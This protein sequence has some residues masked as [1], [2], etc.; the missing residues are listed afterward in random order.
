M[1]CAKQKVEKK[2]YKAMI[3]KNATVLNDKFQF[4][5]ADVSINNGKFEKIGEKLEG[6]IETFDVKGNRIIPGYINIHMHGGV[7]YGVNNADVEGYNKLGRY[8]ASTGTTSYLMTAA[9][10]PKD[11]LI[12][13]VGVIK[14]AMDKGC[15]GANLLGINLEGP[16]LSERYKGAHRAEW[17]RTP[18]QVDFDE[19][20]DAS[21][22]NILVTTIAPEIDGGIDFI[23]THKDKVKISLG[24]TNADY[25]CCMDAFKAGATQ[26][27]HMF[28]AMPSIHH[29]KLSLIAAA[30]E[31]KSMVELICDGYHVDKT[32]VKMAY[33]MFGSDRIIVVNDAESM[34]GQPE[35]E[36]E[37]CGGKVK[38]EGGVARLSD[39]TIAG[40]IA[41]MHQCVTNL[42]SWGVPAE[43][44]IKMASFNP[45]KALDI[46]K[47]GVI[48]EGYDA[49]FSIIDDKFNIKNVY[50]KGKLF[51]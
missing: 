33:E 6:D 26:V 50:I 51:E 45:A 24:H 29:R 23:K 13:Y 22:G 37:A 46:E 19:I 18:K 41:S 17:L 2:G 5:K 48:K 49:D 35:G 34:A 12:K 39:G 47:K 28:N 15:E 11:D 7:G 27:T 36:Y 42:I 31:T 25:D 32:I 1:R 40:G 43:D 10:W 38:V 14:E 16:Y 20:N 8:L 30:F 9:T 21:G 4:Q 3:L 44:A